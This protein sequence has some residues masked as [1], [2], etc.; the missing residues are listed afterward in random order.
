[1]NLESLQKIIIFAVGKDVYT[2][3]LFCCSMQNECVISV[4][5]R[6]NQRQ[7]AM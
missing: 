4:E 5:S 1:M 3:S 2:P 6:C 7:N